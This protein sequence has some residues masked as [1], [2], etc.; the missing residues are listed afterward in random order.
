[1]KEAAEDL[2]KME[3]ILNEYLTNGTSCFI[4]EDLAHIKVTKQYHK[5]EARTL[6]MDNIATT[7]TTSRYTYV[8]NPQT[9]ELIRS[10]A[11]YLSRSKQ[12]QPS[13]PSEQEVDHQLSSRAS[14]SVPSKRPRKEAAAPPTP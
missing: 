4:P 13:P 8:C 5:L 12:Q 2:D 10:P 6:H 11:T 1:M 3:E 9:E 14:T 7:S